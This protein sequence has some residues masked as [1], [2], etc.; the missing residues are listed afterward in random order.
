MGLLIELTVG[1][2]R[3]IDKTY[4][5]CWRNSAICGTKYPGSDRFER[6]VPPR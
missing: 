6:E 3:F 4:L 1:E 5:R 2:G